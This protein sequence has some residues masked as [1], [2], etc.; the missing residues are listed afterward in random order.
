MRILKCERTGGIRETFAASARFKMSQN[1]ESMETPRKN[2]INDEQLAKIAR[3]GKLNTWT[4][5]LL[6]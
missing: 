5:K 1:Q 4:P 2:R 3:N 6:G